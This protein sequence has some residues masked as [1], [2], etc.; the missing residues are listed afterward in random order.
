MWI[1]SC[2]EN[3]AFPK[4][5]EEQ[6][7][8]N[9][10]IAKFMATLIISSSRKD[11]MYKVNFIKLQKNWILFNIWRD[12]IGKPYN[13]RHVCIYKHCILHTYILVCKPLHLAV[14]KTAIK[15]AIPSFILNLATDIFIL[16]LVTPIFIK[17][18]PGLL[19]TWQPLFES[20]IQN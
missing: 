20:S 3:S 12:R 14:W 4:N 18:L 17:Q 7:W 11:T 5:T 6:Y 8:T 1:L 10:K 15:T 2:L 16:H 19:C 9:L 13:F